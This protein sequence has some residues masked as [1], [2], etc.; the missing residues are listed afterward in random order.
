MADIA[1]VHG[2][3]NRGWMMASMAKRL[4]A[5]DHEVKVFSYPTRASDLD[6]HADEYAVFYLSKQLKSYTLRAI[7][8]VA[9]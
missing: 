5:H 2:L 8:W 9:W 1:L 3:W 6:G 7:A 4:R